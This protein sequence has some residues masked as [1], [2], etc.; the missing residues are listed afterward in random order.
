MKNNTIKLNES[1]L[2]QIVAESV[3][4]VLNEYAWASAPSFKELQNTLDKVVGILEDFYY[5][6]PKEQL[7]EFMKLAGKE[8]NYLW[9]SIISLEETVMRIN[10]P[11]GLSDGDLTFDDLS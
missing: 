9:E 10:S 3:K 6:I 2:R 11:R 8:W 1:T 7:D 5:S 4:K